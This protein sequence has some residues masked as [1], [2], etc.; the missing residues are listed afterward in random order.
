MEIRRI[1]VLLQD[2][3]G[4][5]HWN[6]VKAAIKAFIRSNHKIKGQICYG[7]MP[8]QV[9]MLSVVYD[10]LTFPETRNNHDD[11][12]KWNH[13]L[14]HWPFVRGIHPTPVNSPH[15][16]QWRR[17]LVFFYLRLNKWLSKQWWGRWFETPSLPLW[18]HCNVIT[19]T[20][21]GHRPTCGCHFK[22]VCLPCGVLFT[23]QCSR[24]DKLYYVLHLKL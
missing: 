11:I 17:A 14:R 19:A 6:I 18:R 15:K 9:T 4:I 22:N 16:G 5:H 21:H 10:N 20:P 13:F 24:H 1:C 3:I 23:I 7:I 8:W 2:D 12:I